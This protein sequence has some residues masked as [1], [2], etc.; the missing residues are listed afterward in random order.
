LLV[1]KDGLNKKYSAWKNLNID[2][3]TL[4]GYN[5]NRIFVLIL[6]AAMET[7]YWDQ[8][9]RPS[10]QPKAMTAIT[11]LVVH[12]TTGPCIPLFIKW[13]DRRLFKIDEV[14]DVQPNGLSN[15]IYK[16]IIKSQQRIL[17]FRNNRWYIESRE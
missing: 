12:N 2:T 17:Y 10:L 8:L 3:K 6:E 13:S 9:Q 11:V 15:V 14:L 4:C 16:V 1:P 7:D 5:Q